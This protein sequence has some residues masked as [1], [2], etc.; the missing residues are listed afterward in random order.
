MTYYTL[1]NVKLKL[2]IDTGNTSQDTAI[3]NLGADSDNYI[4]TVAGSFTTTPFASPSDQIK[5][6]S[7][8]LTA[9]WYN[10]FNAPDHPFEPVTAVKKEIEQYIRSVYRKSSDTVTSNTWGSAGS[11]MDGTEVS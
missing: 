2:H 10:Y 6:L 9:V 8:K 1:A 11:G 7:D 3:Q 5:A 4:D